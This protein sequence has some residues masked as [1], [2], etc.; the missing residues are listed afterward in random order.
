MARTRASSR[1]TRV[2]STAWARPDGEVWGNGGSLRVPADLGLR[3]VLQLLEPEPDH[4]H[5]RRRQH[6]QPADDRH[7]RRSDPR[8]QSQRLARSPPA[9]PRGPTFD[10]DIEYP[11]PPTLVR[12]ENLLPAGSLARPSITLDDYI[13]NPIGTTHV[14]NLN[15]RH[16]P[17][18]PIRPLEI[19][20]DERA[21]APA[22]ERADQRSSA[23]RRS[24]IDAPT[25]IAG[26]S[27]RW[28]DVRG[29][30][31]IRSSSTVDAGGKDVVLDLDREPCAPT[32]GARLGLHDPSIRHVNAGDD[33]DLVLNDS[34][35]G[36][37]TADSVLVTIK[38]YDP[39]TTYYHYVFPPASRP[40]RQ[41]R[42]AEDPCPLTA[43]C[44]YGSGKYRTHFRP[45]AC[46]PGPDADP[47]RIRHDH[48]RD[49][50]DL[51]LHRPPRRRRH[52]RLPRDHRRR[53]A[54]DLRDH[55][56]NES[57]HVV[58]ADTPTKSSFTSS[59]NGRRP[60][61]ARAVRGID[62]GARHRPAADL[63]P[64]ERVHHR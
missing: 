53:G 62:D 40:H 42:R 17:R 54:E 1:T 56:R 3:E 33:V 45:D 52:R 10:F 19:H 15:R 2:T 6:E 20:Q 58:S 61:L 59:T 29:T 30:V 64:L 18:A 24:D 57:T 31:S 49:R 16:L 8:R 12:I 50:L 39:A 36:N 23:P 32:T 13:E 60:E 26:R 27:S 35:N 37:D 63:H 46:R 11:F 14:E 22:L 5:H 55:G 38:L 41:R 51:R 7:P 44:G 4:E 34:K 47:A 21:R 25:S 28:Q 9:P 43:L 48:D